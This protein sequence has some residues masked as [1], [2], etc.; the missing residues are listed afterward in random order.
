ME[1][2]IPSSNTQLD[3]GEENERT[4]ESATRSSGGCGDE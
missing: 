2:M 4:T 3:R 1:R